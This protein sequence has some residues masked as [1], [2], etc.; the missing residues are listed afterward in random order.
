MVPL[1]NV[2]M[3]IIVVGNNVSE[4]T[5]SKINVVILLDGTDLLVFNLF[6]SFIAF[7]P[8]GV[9]ADPRPNK[10]ARIF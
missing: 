7:N 9:A 8:S 5:L 2:L 4:L 1:Y 6:N 10:F 3:L